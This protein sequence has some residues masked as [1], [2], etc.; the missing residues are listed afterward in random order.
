LINQGF[1]AHGDIEL[2]KIKKRVSGRKT[3][4]RILLTLISI[5]NSAF[6]FDF[7]LGGCRLVSVS[8]TVDGR[9]E[10]TVD[11][12][13]DLIGVDTEGRGVDRDSFVSSSVSD[14]SFVTILE[15]WR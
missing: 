14:G 12:C 1:V 9:G 6:C 8:C 3:S 7:F 2:G 10:S 5:R 11:C 4:L 15:A 13:S